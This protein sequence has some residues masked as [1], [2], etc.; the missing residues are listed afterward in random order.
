[1][2][3]ANCPRMVPENN[4]QTDKGERQQARQSV[5]SRCLRP[6][7]FRDSLCYACLFCKSEISSKFN[8]YTI[9]CHVAWEVVKEWNV[10]GQ[11]PQLFL[12]TAGGSPTLCSKVSS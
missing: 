2:I 8:A 6:R 11:G 3:C 12:G 9:T 4:V 5:S 1:M 10:G 7:G